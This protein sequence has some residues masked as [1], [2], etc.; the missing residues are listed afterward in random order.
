MSQTSTSEKKT[1][2]KGTPMGVV[3]ALREPK[4]R[5]RKSV[6]EAIRGQDEGLIVG[7]LGPSSHKAVDI[8][9]LNLKLEPVSPSMGTIVHGINLV[10]DCKKPEIVEFLRNLWL[11]RRVIMFRGQKNLSRDGLI[12]FAEC[13][14]ELGSHHG[15]RDHIPSAPMSSDDYPDILEL[16]S[17]EKSPSAASEWHSDATWSPRPPMGSILICREA[18]PVGGD[19]NFCDAY[20]LWEGLHPS[21]KDQVIGLSA[22]HIGQPHHAMDGKLPEA[23]HPVARTHPETGKTALFVNRVFTKRFAETH[24]FDEETTQNLLQKLFERIGRPEIS[25]RFKWTSGSVA[26]WDN[27]AVQHCATADFWPHRRIMERVTIL[28]RE[29][30]RRSPYFAG[31]N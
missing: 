26:M 22:V 14:G 23:I 19:T 4:S 11:E 16:K 18:P 29:I 1:L 7:Q 28:D 2:S 12:K 27:R 9:G 24:N 13:F 8:Y 17:G 5:D 10:T 3:A 30:G 25:C 31:T 6:A 20:G 21:I 15:E